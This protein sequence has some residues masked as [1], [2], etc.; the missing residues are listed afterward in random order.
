MNTPIKQRI[1]AKKCFMD[2][3]LS[4]L[5]VISISSLFYYIIIQENMSLHDIC[6]YQTIAHLH[7]VCCILK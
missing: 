1:I 4:P 6:P 7:I 2:K 3:F 5:T